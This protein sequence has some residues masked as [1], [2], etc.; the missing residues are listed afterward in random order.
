MKV[1]KTFIH[2]LLSA[3]LAYQS[4]RLFEASLIYTGNYN[5][6]ESFFLAVI[7]NLFITGTFAFIGFSIPTSK[8]LP[9]SFYL[10]KNKHF[11]NILYRSMGV[12]YFRYFLLSTFWRNKAKQKTF[13]NGTKSGLEEFIYSSH[14]AEFGHLGAFIIILFYSALM[15]YQDA[16]NT[17]II[18]TIINIFFNF[19]P[20]ILQRKHR[21]RIQKI[22]K[23][24]KS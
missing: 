8:L 11:L 1:G 22:L 23:S 18:S 19:Y 14:Q 5:L 4:Y 20:V 6:L 17:F 21:I 16:Y 10:V 3:F 24:K 12:K 15:L 9:K 13:F 7:A 2:I